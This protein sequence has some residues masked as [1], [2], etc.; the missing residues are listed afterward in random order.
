MP[1]PSCGHPSEAGAR[2]CAAC[3][4]PLAAAP[5]TALPR[6]PDHLAAKIL[7]SRATIEGER[8]QV[9]VLFADV[10]GS[11]DLAEGLDPED[12]HHV[13]QRFAGLL[14]DG[15]HRFEGTVAQFT[16]DGIMALF[17][18]PI[19]H[20]DHA[21]RACWAALHLRDEL[22]RY[23]DELRLAKGLNFS[24]RTGLNSGE[25]VVGQIG[26]DLRMD[27]T[28]RGH[29]V[30]L[31]ARMEQLAEPGHIYLT[32]H[33][34]RLVAGFF[35]LRDL[36]P[37]AVKGASA[38][39]RIH[40]LEGVGPLRTRL[41]ASRRRGFS[42]FVGRT[43][44]MATLEA[45][46]AQALDGAGQVAS[47]VG[48]AGV[49]KS[50]LCHEFLERC[51]A[52]GI[53]VY[54]GHCLAHGR[55]LPYLPVLEMVRH[56]FGVAEHDRDEEARRKIAGTVLLLD[57]SL[58]DALP[59]LFDFLGVADPGHPGRRLDA[60]AGERALTATIRR[61]AETRSRE[62]PAVFLV[63][64]VHW[65]DAGS[66]Q[67][68][69]S[70]A[71]WIGATRTLLVANFRPEYDDARL[72][73]APYRRIALEPLGTDAAATLL[74]ELL[75]NDGSVADLVPRILERTA[76]NPFFIEEIVQA[77]AESGGLEGTKGA[78][79]LVRPTAELVLPPTV[80]SVLTARIDRLP[81][82]E[83]EVLQT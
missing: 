29:T 79:R 70:M 56:Y 20:E 23:A 7:A 75:G 35:R 57:E 50:R 55:T 59:L 54:E 31:A 9:T 21:A 26:D 10:K 44:E 80:Q 22:R 13:M 16:G 45:A 64:D 81:E 1:C 34:A 68:V 32:E 62:R 14:A 30:G 2:F 15:I 78:Y 82:R 41:D 6:T 48:L 76:G 39:I 42:R 8:K 11:M 83:K 27:W 12:F 69:A 37:L 24:V 49:G 71:E 25:V 63:D 58:R 66:E 18:A 73:Q 28:A 40:E 46:L 53:P 38:P 74:R 43:D 51:R 77:L 52:R 17:G 19:A 67:F 33:T 72:R 4:T 60:E 36:G 47:V 3:G 65:I 61:I 5:A